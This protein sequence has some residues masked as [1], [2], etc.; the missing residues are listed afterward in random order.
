[1]NISSKLSFALAATILLGACSD[2]TKQA[3]EQ[4][5]AAPV[6]AV[7]AAPISV[8][9]VQG[10][11]QKQGEVFVHLFEWRWPEIAAECEGF[12][13]PNG[14]AAVQVSPPQEHIQGPQWWT[15]YQPVSYKIESRGG[16]R[17]EFA[18]MVKRCK[19]AGV[20]VYVDA[21][22]NHMADVT[23]GTGVAG[24]EFGDY[25][26]PVP[27]DYDDFHHCGRNGD[28]RIADY[29]DLW[30]VRN[31]NLGTL[32]DLDT[33]NPAVQ[34]KIAAYLNDLL[35]LGVAGFRLDAIKHVQQDEVNQIL[36][37]LDSSPFIYQEVPDPGSEPINSMDY[38]INGSVVEFKYASELASAF[39]AARLD[40]LSDFGSRAG[41]LPA[42][43]AVVFVDNHD[44]QRGHG[45]VDEI[46]NYKSGELYDLANVF[47]LGWP[48][49]YPKVMSSYRFEGSSQ[50]PPGSKPV[51]A[52]A[53]T[54]GWVCEHRGPS[55]VGMIGFRKATEGAPVTSWQAFGEE[56]ISFGRGD[57]GHVI[58]NMGPETVNGTFITT[59][60]PGE[61]CN[62]V[63][64]GTPENDCNG[65]VVLVGDDGVLQISVPPNSAVA[66][67]HNAFK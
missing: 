26:F 20:D 4:K 3:A 41:Y 46:L 1:M 66:I 42:D 57:K 5:H 43:D 61:Y 11:A 7:Q 51:Q 21:I 52:G 59:M 53:C 67:H 18:D 2:E 39:I 34:K 16:T 31:C 64:A 33:S 35:S 62:V 45:A 44:T 28:D 36:S 23:P 15:R 27:Y 60:A 14:Y 29:Q 58:I 37:Q 17:V 25:V 65:S 38:L 10:S 50:G 6:E 30:E 63:S 32:A 48:Y 12:L 55:I 56:V 49:G 47:M 40:S 24:S 8:K 22:T 9:P 54:S 19:S 13:G